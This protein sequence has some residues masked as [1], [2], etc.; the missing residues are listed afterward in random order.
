[1]PILVYNGVHELGDL[2]IQLLGTA[3]LAAEHLDTLANRPHVLRE[4][5]EVVDSGG[6]GDDNFAQPS[7]NIIGLLEDAFLELAWACLAALRPT[8]SLRLPVLKARCGRGWLR[9]RSRHCCNARA[10]SPPAVVG[11]SRPS[12]LKAFDDSPAPVAYLA[13]RPSGNRAADELD[14]FLQP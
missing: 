14:L 5:R 8:K 10:G 4:L 9:P 2:V 3:N 7:A 1:M 6:D 12:S 13:M 11:E